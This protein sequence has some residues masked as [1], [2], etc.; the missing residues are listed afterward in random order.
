MQVHADPHQTFFLVYDTSM[1]LTTQ[2]R[3]DITYTICAFIISL[4]VAAWSAVTDCMLLCNAACCCITGATMSICDNQ[5]HCIEASIHCKQ[6]QTSI[7][8]SSNSYACTPEV[9]AQWLFQFVMWQYSS[10]AV[11]TIDIA[12]CVAAAIEII[13]VPLPPNA[14]KPARFPLA[15]EV[16]AVLLWTKIPPLQCGKD[17]LGQARG[18]LR[19]GYTSSAAWLKCLSCHRLL[20]SVLAER[21]ARHQFRV[22]CN[23]REAARACLLANFEL[24]EIS[25]SWRYEMC[26]VSSNV[27][28]G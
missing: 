18:H 16:Y 11:A 26:L 22:K 15:S 9:L 20:L 28:A 27:I 2:C 13:R 21:S 24:E 3:T 19:A 4:C 8:C 14:P 1:Q 12:L 10:K 17:S 25:R 7:H 6:Q 23:W 5:Q